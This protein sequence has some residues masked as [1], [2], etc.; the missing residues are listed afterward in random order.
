MEQLDSGAGADSDHGGGR[1][2]E[3]ETER[4]SRGTETELQ[5]KRLGQKQSA[6]LCPSLQLPRR[7]RW[8]RKGLY[9]LYN[10]LYDVLRGLSLGFIRALH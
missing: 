2:P 7:P 3:P 1:E 10:A 4:Q 6:L 5:M 8:P 9:Q